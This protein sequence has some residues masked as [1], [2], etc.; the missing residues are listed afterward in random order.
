MKT[1]INRPLLPWILGTTLIILAFLAG[2]RIWAL[3]T[4]LRVQVASRLEEQLQDRV[5]SWEDN[6]IALLDD[7]M[8]QLSTG[9]YEPY[10]RQLQLRHR[11]KWF[12]SFYLW[13][14]PTKT[15]LTNRT[16]WTP[17]KLIYPKAATSEESIW[18]RAHPCIRS[19][20]IFGMTRQYETAQIIQTMMSACATHPAPVRIAA[21]MEAAKLYD[22]TG[23]SPAALEILD[24]AGYPPERPVKH[25]MDAGISPF[26]A[27]ALRNLQA[28]LMKKSGMQEEYLKLLY[29][30]GL[31]LTEMNAPDATNTRQ[32]LVNIIDTLEV[33]GQT[34]DATRLKSNLD[35]INR[36]IRAWEEVSNRIIP[37]SANLIGNR[38]RFVFDQ[39]RDTPYLIYYGPTGNDRQGVAIQMDQSRVLANFLK[40]N[41]RYGTGLRIT[42]TSGQWVAGTRHEAQASEI[43]VPFA[44]SLTHLKV[45]LSSAFVEKRVSGLNEQWIVPLIVTGFC[46]LLGFFALAAQIQANRRLQQLVTR[47][48]EFTTRVTHELKTPIAGIRIMAENLE[49]GVY[50]SDVQRAQ[51]ARQIITETDRLTKRVDEVLT[52]T[53]KPTLATTEPFDMEEI[54]FALVDLWG[55][56]FE[57]QGVRF[58]AEIEVAP[59]LIGDGQ[60][61]RD[62][63]GCLLDNALKYKDSTLEESWVVLKLSQD[64]AYAKIEVSDNGLGVPKAMRQR[65]FDRFQRVEGPNRGKAGGHGLGLAQVA[66]V[67]RLHNGTIECLPNDEKGACFILRIRGKK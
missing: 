13:K 16:E 55:P 49:T 53:R 10:K 47:Q 48:R 2:S 30:T 26:R 28:N 45:G 51:T 12:D 15:T 60:E 35:Q 64:G 59:E 21:A 42:D 52:H 20:Q 8:E 31:E 44:K 65:I 18:M 57:Q 24:R 63:I 38:P 23:Q 5:D 27:V 14:L 25:I 17:A 9:R 43:Q 66:A 1:P 22:K 11:S 61:V 7:W 39:Y 62:A 50:T 46:V 3:Q 67:A 41:R 36:R 34:T 32:Y 37:E 4:E 19:A 58:S 6:F 29:Q 33:N 40:S 56:R 54:C